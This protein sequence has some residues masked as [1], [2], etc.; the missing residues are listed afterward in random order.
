MSKIKVA[1]DLVDAFADGEYKLW[2]E[3]NHFIDRKIDTVL[4]LNDYQKFFVAKLQATGKSIGQ[5]NDEEKKEF[6]TG[7]KKGWAAEKNK[8]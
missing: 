2:L 7:V 1:E 4:E 6:F 5:M 8:K 3:F